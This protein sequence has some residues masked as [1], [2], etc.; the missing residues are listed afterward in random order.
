MRTSLTIL[1]AAAASLTLVTTG[2]YRFTRNPMYLSL[3]LLQLGIALIM[4]SAWVILALIPVTVIMN[5]GV[6]EREEA[7]MTD[8]FGQRYLDYKTA[9]R[10]WL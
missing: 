2:P 1:A 10:R 9:V 5:E 3:T 8:H 4:G 6:I 7:Y